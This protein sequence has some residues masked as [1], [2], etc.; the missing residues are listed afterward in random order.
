MR[1]F[2][3]GAGNAA[4]QLVNGDSFDLNSFL[5]D[6]AISGTTA[7]ILGSFNQQSEIA[8]YAMERELATAQLHAELQSELKPQYL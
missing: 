5:W 4:Y 8:R 3:G 6:A 1:I 7:G 2:S